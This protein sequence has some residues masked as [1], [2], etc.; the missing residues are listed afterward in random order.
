M[1]RLE[2]KIFRN[3]TSDPPDRDFRNLSVFVFSTLLLDNG[4]T[5]LKM[6]IIPLANLH[7]M[8]KRRVVR[9]SQMLINK[10]TFAWSVVCVGETATVSLEMEGLSHGA[11]PWGSDSVREKTVMRQPPRW[12]QNGIKEQKRKPASRLRAAKTGKT[13]LSSAASASLHS[14]P[15][16]AERSQ[17]NHSLA[18]PTRS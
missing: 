16:R 11:R 14:R 13:C 4:F 9:T 7:S 2:T 6:I 18:S 15:T 10:F 8:S 5:P 12:Q 1:A 3:I 17:P